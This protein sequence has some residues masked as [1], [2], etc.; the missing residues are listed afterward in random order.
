MDDNTI[1][2]LKQFITSAIHQEV[3]VIREDVK[4]LDEKLA[5]KMD[6]LSKCSCRSIGYN[7]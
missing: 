6:D 1:Q 2:D 7:K 4:K 5:T 3:V